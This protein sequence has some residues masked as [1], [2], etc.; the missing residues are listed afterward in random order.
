MRYWLRRV[1]RATL[2]LDMVTLSVLLIA[3]LFVPH[4]EEMTA[5]LLIL[6]MLG[7]VGRLT[8]L[9]NYLR[10]QQKAEEA[11]RESQQRLR[12]ALDIAR[13]GTWDW[14]LLTNENWWGEETYRLIG[15]KEGEL[16]STVDGFLSRIFPDDLPAVQQEIEIC[17]KTGKPFD[18]EYRIHHPDG[19]EHWMYSKG[20]TRFDASGK[21]VFMIGVVQDVTAR[22]R[23]EQARLELELAQE[24]VNMLKDFLGTLSHDLKTPL[25][26]LTTGLYLVDKDSNPQQRHER[27]ERLQEQVHVLERL[28]QDALMISRLD[29]TPAQTAE[30]VNV[31]DL[32]QD[33]ARRL[34][35]QSEKKNIDFQLR[36]DH[37]LPSI[38]ADGG[39]LLRALLNLTENA[40]NYTPE[41]G[42]VSLQTTHNHDTVI[43]EVRD[44]GHG[45]PQEDLPHIFNRFYRSKTARTL[46]PTGSGLGLAIVKRVVERHNGRIDVE[47]TPNVGSTFRLHLPLQNAG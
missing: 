23:A 30:L 43:I 12:I 5:F 14:D 38:N 42:Q 47:S 10:V 28:I 17:R 15:V 27:I 41:H 18:L 20:Q 37:T 7:V 1:G 13:M 22:K 33:V 24:R 40:L 32:A 44:S 6:L 45:I 46:V 26:A 16:T 25:T 2:L 31:S 35:P 8:I 29:A 3:L 9:Y 4:S 36:L 39:D 19:T 34:Q 11:P 21:P